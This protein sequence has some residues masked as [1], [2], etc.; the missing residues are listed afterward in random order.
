MKHYYI[1]KSKKDLLP[2]SYIIYDTDKNDLTCYE[3]NGWTSDE[4]GKFIVPS[5][6]SYVA[7]VYARF[8]GCTHWYF[9]GED[10]RPEDGRD[11]DSYYHICGPYCLKN[12]MT[13]MCFI[14]EVAAREHIE[15]RKDFYDDLESLN[16]IRDLI[17][18]EY[19]IVEEESKEMPI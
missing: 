18:A 6:I 5:D 13:H 4:N 19:E 17:L 9:R 2:V 1:L 16:K 7:G 15:H 11:F 10:Y 3:V 14:W 12:M 8:D